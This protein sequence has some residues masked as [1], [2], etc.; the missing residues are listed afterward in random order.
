MQTILQGLRDLD[1]VHGTFVADATGQVLA[2]NAESIYD[3]SLLQQ[4]SKAI[5]TAIDSVKLLEEHW[6]TITAQFAEGRVLVRS[7]P[8][9][10]RSK[11]QTLT[12]SL[13]AD[14]RLNPSFATVAIR[15]A[16]AKIKSLIE[17]NGGN[18]PVVE[19]IQ[20]L[21]VSSLSVP[22]GPTTANAVPFHAG[23]SASS[24]TQS[25]TG[26]PQFTASHAIAAPP[27]VAASGLSWS[28]L[29]GSSS[30]SASGVSVADAASSAA[31]TA[32]TKCLARAVGP[33]AKVFVKEAVRKIAQNQPFA[34][35]MLAALISEL[36]KGIEDTADAKEFRKAATKL[37]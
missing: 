17:A 22:L 18:L 21:P 30:L 11:S 6:D 8:N 29:G 7:I 23:L 14:T 10:G 26:V 33:M 28:G 36:E 19:A 15:V 9:V 1:G 5:A 3:A 12:L 34:K 25:V 4:V 13:I 20:P 35:S 27:E 31:L 32:C 16:I 2:F 24:P 37:V